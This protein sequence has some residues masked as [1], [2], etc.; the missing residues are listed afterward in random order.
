MFDENPDCL[1]FIVQTSKCSNLGCGEEYLID[2]ENFSLGEEAGFAWN[3]RICVIRAVCFF[4]F[5]FPSFYL[6]SLE[7]SNSLFGLHSSL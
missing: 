6:F 7:R 2:A 3:G 4:F 1:G 5:F